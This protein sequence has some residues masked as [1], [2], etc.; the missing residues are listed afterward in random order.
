MELCEKG[1]LLDYLKDQTY[2]PQ[3]Q[4]KWCREVSVCVC[5]RACVCV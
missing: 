2:T 3:Q 5:V 1:A 4:L